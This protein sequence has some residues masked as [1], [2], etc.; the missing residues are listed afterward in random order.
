MIIVWSHFVT[1]DHKINWSCLSLFKFRNQNSSTEIVKPVYDFLR[2][3]TAS[4]RATANKC[5]TMSFTQHFMSSVTATFL[6]FFSRIFEKVGLHQRWLLILMALGCSTA[7]GVGQWYRHRCCCDVF[8]EQSQHIVAGDG[9]KTC[10]LCFETTVT[11]SWLRCVVITSPR[12]GT[13][14]CDWCFKA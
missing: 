5:C 11:C 4:H 12:T 9:V 2:N 1:L 3:F 6:F 10:R 7:T 14:L 13:N 8:A